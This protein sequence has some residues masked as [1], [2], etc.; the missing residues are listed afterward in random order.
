MNIFK[1]IL[2]QKLIL[3]TITGVCI[4]ILLGLILKTVTLQPWTKRNIMY[5]RFP[6]EL[7]MR[8]VN[9]LILP[10][11]TSTIISATC[12]LKKSGTY[13]LISNFIKLTKFFSNV[14]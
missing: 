5:L 11:I 12:D 2:R 6:G 9:C 7:F 13:K 4:G 3:S 8:M 14:V 10:L 1:K